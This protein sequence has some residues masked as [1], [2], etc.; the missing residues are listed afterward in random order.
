MHGLSEKFGVNIFLK[1]EDLQT[2]L[3]PY[4]YEA[5]TTKSKLFLMKAKVFGKGSQMQENHA[6]VVFSYKQP[7]SKE[8]FYT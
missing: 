7:K 5:H 2:C 3:D 1:R 4:K 8:R 6:S